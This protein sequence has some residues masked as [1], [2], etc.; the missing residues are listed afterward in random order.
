[1]IK[2]SYLIKCEN[3]CFAAVRWRYFNNLPRSFREFSSSI[4]QGVCKEG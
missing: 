4:T 2:D 3:I 1:M